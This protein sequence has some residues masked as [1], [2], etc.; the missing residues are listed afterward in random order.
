MDN[1][2][3]YVTGSALGDLDMTLHDISQYLQKALGNKLGV[4]RI[5]PPWVDPKDGLQK[6]TEPEELL[7]RARMVK[8]LAMR[9]SGYTP[10]PWKHDKK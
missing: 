5:E 6:T 4:Y 8:D 3:K 10:L 2:K 9:V 7:R 1:A